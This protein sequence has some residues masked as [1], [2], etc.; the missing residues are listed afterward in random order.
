V[1]SRTPV[2]DQSAALHDLSPIQE[3]R[4]WNRQ[5]EDNIVDRMERMG[6]IA[7][8]GDVDKILNTVVNNLQVTNNL[9]MDVRCRVLM[10]ST[11]ESFTVGHTIVLSR[12]LV[13]VL[14]DEASLAAVLAHE[15]SHVIIGG[16]VD[17][18]WAFYD[19]LL[20]DDKNTFHHFGFAHTEA[21][22]QAAN[23]KA[24]AL[25]GNS[26]YK[27]Q[28]QSSR[29]FLAELNKRAPQI[30]NLIS[31]HMGHSA[32][33]SLLSA[34][35]GASQQSPTA[36]QIAALP[37]GGRV[38]LDPWGDNLQMLQS[39]PV[40]AETEAERMPFEVTPFMLYL[41]RNNDRDPAQAQPAAA[42]QP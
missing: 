24:V 39:K 31:M 26:P 17:T 35:K 2:E 29:L 13:D 19:R 21:E 23:T 25:L 33:M 34:S 4:A 6:L 20:F 15:L 42:T 9:D 40:T 11:L 41:V 5:A 8:P 10:T 37:L 22:E 32:V 28:L 14:P 30:P 12:G 7:P 38:K 18:K 1:E 16:P 36:T 3:Q 27:D